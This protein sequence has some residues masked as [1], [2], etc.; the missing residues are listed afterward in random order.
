MRG[1]IMED[2]NVLA[3]DLAKTSFQIHG[4]DKRARNYDSE[5]CSVSEESTDR[6][7]P[8]Q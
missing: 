6:Y 3:I 5:E 2:I 8:L 1:T 4:N 7:Y